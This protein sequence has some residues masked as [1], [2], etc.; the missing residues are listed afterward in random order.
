MAR[1]K[2][3]I[4]ERRADDGRLMGYQVKIRKQGFPTVNRQ[5]DRKAE[6]ERFALDTL[7]AMTARTWT[8]RREAERTTLAAALDQYKVEVTATKKTA[9]GEG[10]LIERLKKTRLA[11]YSLATIQ[12]SDIAS[13]RD[14][15]LG[16]PASEDL[17]FDG[18]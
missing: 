5:F 13:Y 6:A 11:E 10:L 14:L 1:G 2:L 16:E 17:S 18:P 3:P 9:Y 7:Q 15:R 8:D 12:G 4:F